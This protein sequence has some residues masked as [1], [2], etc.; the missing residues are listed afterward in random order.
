MRAR[1]SSRLCAAY[2]HSDVP[3]ELQLYF[4]QVWPLAKCDAEDGR[5]VGHLLAGLVYSKPKDLAHAIREFANRTVMLRECG[6]RHVGAMLAAMLT[7][8][9]T[10][11]D[12]EQASNEDAAR[13]L[14]S[15]TAN[16]ASALGG[17]L[18]E[19]RNGSSELPATALRQVVDSHSILRMMKTQHS[20]FVPMLEVLAALP[21]ATVDASIES[22]FASSRHLIVLN[23]ALVPTQHC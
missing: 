4:Q 23:P 2:P 20:W 9:S 3:H 16:Q 18:A 15:V 22:R 1:K 14:A 5:I 6:F 21:D 7:M 17:M 8:Q 19:T 10:R 12:S 13:D 11:G